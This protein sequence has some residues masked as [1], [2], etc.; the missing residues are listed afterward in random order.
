MQQV[1]AC[2]DGRFAF[3]DSDKINLKK[4][5]YLTPKDGISLLDL[6][7]GIEDSSYGH[8]YKLLFDGIAA[9]APQL[10]D[11]K[12]K[13][14]YEIERKEGN[15]LIVLVVVSHGPLFV[16][17][18][19]AQRHDN[20]DRD[21]LA[22]GGLHLQ[23]YIP[24]ADGSLNETP[25]EFRVHFADSIF[26]CEDQR[27]LFWPAIGH[28]LDIPTDLSTS[29]LALAKSWLAD[30]TSRQGRHEGCGRSEPHLLP[31]R[32]I[33]V[34]TDTTA[35]RLYV[36]RSGEK[37]FWL[38]LSHCWG[39]AVPTKTTTITLDDFTKELPLGLPQT[40]AD[41]IAV[42]R[43]LGQRFLWIDSLCILQDSSD[44][45]ITESSRMDQV[46]SQALVTI[47]ADA[48]ENLNSMSGFLRPPARRVRKISIIHYD[49]GID[50]AKRDLARCGTV[51]VRE[52][53]ELAIQLPYHDVHPG[54][55]FIGTKKDSQSKLSTRAWAFQ[56]RVLSP[57]T[58]HFGPTEMA[59]ECRALCSCECSATNERTALVTGLLK[60]SKALQPYLHS[61]QE[62]SQHVFRRLDDA[63]QRDIVEE[64]T[65]LHLTVETD[66]LS[67][68]AGIATVSS[69]LRPG[70]QYMS[71]MWRNTLAA[72]LSWFTVP[73]R[74]SARLKLSGKNAP[75]K[76]FSPPTWSW[77]SVSGQIKH[78]RLAG[79]P[80]GAPLIKVLNISYQP[81]IASPMGAG[82]QTPASLLAWGYVVPIESVWF[83]EYR[84]KD[85][86]ICRAESTRNH[87]RVQWPTGLNL[88]SNCVAMMDVHKCIP[89]FDQH[90]RMD[91]LEGA[92]L[93]Q[94]LVM[95][96]TALA[97]GNV[98]GLILERRETSGAVP[99]YERIGFVNGTDVMGDI[100]Q[101]SSNYYVTMDL[102]E[103]EW[104]FDEKQ[105][106]SPMLGGIGKMMIKI[107]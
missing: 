34:G 47:V 58:L 33:D 74:A 54:V 32:V 14:E 57:R 70:D 26:I 55:N 65:R 35:P 82:P 104:L 27:P 44:D 69:N 19:W 22:P 45:W 97:Q 88:P 8:R 89:V 37:G 73:D 4:Y 42:T 101:W 38:A 86:G 92:E 40:F 10:V 78:A 23:F 99:A 105:G 49:L 94:G 18:R 95:L 87:Y 100:I 106:I 17:V 29:E 85:T 72:S 79:Y 56:E 83:Q 39:G 80:L 5:D 68:L 30:C 13:S 41:A 2:S 98:Y 60:I 53:G 103:P 3:G 63:W 93:K 6:R 67:A 77:G 84:W 46:Y 1:V 62:S 81:N 25:H 52:R 11:R 75:R 12:E 15:I 107:W 59:W 16:D 76:W 31:T 90:F 64:Y 61:Q 43:I 48:A 71:G 24:H 102:E 7:R 66:R 91:R 20:S 51:H 36:S 50:A 28:G 9:V 96:L 21:E